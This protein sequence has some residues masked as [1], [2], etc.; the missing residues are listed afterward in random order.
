LG[1]DHC[2]ASGACKSESAKMA[3]Q[4]PRFSR[5][6]VKQIIRTWRRLR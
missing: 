4:P 1:L 6:V 3:A 5:P 2:E